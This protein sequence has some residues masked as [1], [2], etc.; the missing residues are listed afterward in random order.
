MLGKTPACTPAVDLEVGDFTTLRGIYLSVCVASLVLVALIPLDQVGR[1]VG[2]LIM[3]I[4]FA[5]LLREVKKM[6]SVRALHLEENH[7]VLVGDAFRESVSIRGYPLVAPFCIAF[8]CRPLDVQNKY[9]SLPNRL[10]F[11]PGTL[12]LDD[13]RVLRL[14]LKK[15]SA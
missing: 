11:V 14:W 7:M 2:F 9:Q 15:Q 12:S 1:A 8:E 6:M 4:I 5:K 13:E 10:V 3:L